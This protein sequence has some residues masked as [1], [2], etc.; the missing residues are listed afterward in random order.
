MK[1][2]WGFFTKEALHI[3]RDQRTLLILFGLPLIQ[4]LLF[5][6]ALRNDLKEI[7]LAVLDYAQ[8]EESRQL[9][10]S[11]FASGYFVITA[12]L[13]S[14]EEIECVFKSAKA[15]SALVIREIDHTLE[16]Q[17]IS[18]ATDP[19]T[20]QLITGYLQAIIA[21]QNG[22]PTP[23]VNVE[24]RLLYNPTM[25]STYGFVPGLFA[26][27]LMIVSALMTS[28][29]ITREKEI[30]TMEMLLVSP[31]K[32]LQIIIGKVLPY[33]LLSFVNVITILVLALYVFDVPFVG[34]FAVFFLESL[35]YVLTALGLGMLISTITDSQ[36]VAMMISLAG[37]LLPT[38]ILSGFIFPIN[39]MPLPLRVASNIIPA[40][41]YLTA[42][43][44]IMLKG[45]DLTLLWKETLVLAGMATLLLTVSIKKFQIR[46]Q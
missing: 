28:I 34:S 41:W 26:L 40:T 32:P 38:I 24:T 18:D 14:E 30:G 9:K 20:A 43:K 13:N 21:Q 11:L 4:L 46:L 23:I 22:M 7:D 16:Y 36:Q 8:T 37:L 39:N 5:G 17:I 1:S 6:F 25:E 42:A 44:S 35:L 15:Q 33:L 10:Q 12:E 45:A 31:L 2:F 19:N 3:I 29:T 27:I